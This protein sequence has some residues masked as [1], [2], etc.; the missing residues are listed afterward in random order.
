MNNDSISHPKAGDLLISEPFL[1]DEN[2][3]RSV[4]LLCEHNEEG[5]FGLVF[6]KPSILKLHEIIDGIEL[7]D[8]EVFVGGPVE[9][10]TLHF[11]YFGEKVLE[12]SVQLGAQ[13]WWGGDFEQL[14]SLL[15]NKLLEPQA[16][17]FFIGYSGWDAGQLSDELQDQ[18]WVIYQDDVK[19][20]AFNND[21]QQ[22]WRSL[23]IEMGGEYKVIANYPPDPRLN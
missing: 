4:V 19:S 12:G 10:N 15:R 6:N 7:T 2:F 13:L 11:V 14:M 17:R 20:N 22:L 23:L 21:P 8:L 3:S 16:I 9:Q 5:S 18:V 1:Q